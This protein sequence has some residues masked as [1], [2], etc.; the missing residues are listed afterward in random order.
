MKQFHVIIMKTARKPQAYTRVKTE[1]S[2][3]TLPFL[4]KMRIKP[5]TMAA[6]VKRTARTIIPSPTEKGKTDISLP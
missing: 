2:R 4:T 6:A 1:M 5:I 3:F